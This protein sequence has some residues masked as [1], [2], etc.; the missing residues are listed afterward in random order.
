MNKNRISSTM[1]R[2]IRVVILL[3]MFFSNLDFASAETAIPQENNS[4]ARA[5]NNSSVEAETTPTPA[6][7]ENPTSI[8]TEAGALPEPARP[9][10]LLAAAIQAGDYPVQTASSLGVTLPDRFGP[11]RNDPAEGIPDHAYSPFDESKNSEHPCP[12]GGCD[13]VPGQVLVKFEPGL[14]MTALSVQGIIQ[15]E[16]VFP[17]ASAPE[18]GAQVISPD[19]SSIPMPDLTLWYRATFS[20]DLDVTSVVADLAGTPGIQQAAP[21][22]LRKPVGSF[23]EPG[24]PDAIPSAD[25]TTAQAAFSDPLYAQQWHLGAANVPQA[26]DY[27]ESQGLPPG[28]SRDIIVAVIDTGVDYTHPDLAANMWVN[29]AEFGG[30]PGV[31][32]DGN[33]FVDDIYGA[34]VVSNQHSGDPMDDHGHGTHV[35][36]II[37][38]QAGNGIGGV[39]V[40]YNVQIMAIK[41]AQYSGALSSSDIAEGVYYAVQKGADVINM[42]F[43]GYARSQVEE[44]ALAVAFGQAVLVAAAGNDGLVNLPCP[45]GRDMYPAAYNWVLGVMASKQASDIS[46]WQ[47]GFSNFDCV[48]HDTHEYELMAPGVDIWS[49]LPVNQYAAWDGTSMAAPIVSGIAALAR[50][51]WSDKDLYSSRFIMGQIAA[52]AAPVANAYAALTVAPQPELKYMEH[53]LFD[54]AA[55]ATGNDADGIVDAGETIDLAIVIRNHWGKADPVSVKLE[56]WAEGAFQADPYVTMITDTVDYGAIGSYNWDD[57]GLIYDSEGIITGVGNPF[58]FSVDPNTP[59]DHIIPFLLTMTTHNGLDP[60]DTTVY[61]FQSRFYL[62]VQRGRELPYIISENM[63]LTK[64]YY[65]LVS[66]Q[67]LIPAGVTLTI[68]EGTQIQFWTSDPEDPYHQNV[69]PYLQVE[70][71][72]I[73]QGLEYEPVEFFSGANYS[74]FAVQLSQVGNGHVE[75]HYT[76]VLNPLLGVTPSSGNAPLDLIDHVYFAQEGSNSFVL[77]RDDTGRLTAAV[78]TLRGYAI[79][80]SILDKMGGGDG[81]IEISS[82]RYR[83]YRVTSSL[84][85]STLFTLGDYYWGSPPIDIQDTV[86]LVN[87]RDS[88]ASNAYG[89]GY[90]CNSCDSSIGQT[91]NQVR[92]NA[93]LNRW[94]DPD[95]NHWMRITALSMAEFLGPV[96]RNW[97]FYIN[98][99]FWGTTSTTLIN[100]AI[101][102]FNDNFNLPHIE[103]Q[104]ILTT[105]PETAYPFVVDVILSTA[106]DPDAAVVSAEPVTFTVTFNRDMDTA[107]QPAVSFGPDVPLTD[108]TIHPID[109]GWQDPRTWTGTFNVNPMTGDGYQLIRVAG[110][111]AVDDPWLVTGDDAGRFRFE[112]ITSGTESMNLQATGGEGYVDLSWTQDDFEL[113]SGFNLYR[114]TSQAGAYSRINSSIIPPAERSYRDTSVTPGQPYYYKFTIVK[115]DMSE[116]DFSNLTQ[117]TPLDT[118]PP[119]LIHTAITSA[120]PGLPLTISAEATDNVAVTGLTLYYRH[121]GET[122][123]LTRAMLNTTGNSY[124]ATIEG[125]RLTSPGL[126]YYLEATDGISFTRN[127]RAENPNIVMVDDRPVVTIVTPN[128]GLAA[129]G[130]LVTISGSNFKAGATVKFGGSIASNVVVVSSNQITATTPAHYPAM[131]DVH[132]NNPDAQ[133]GVLLNGFT[134]ESPSALISLPETGGGTGNVLTVPINAANVHGMVA[135]SLTVSY[136]P[137]VIQ[138]LSASTG[139]LTAG[140]TLASNLATVG[141]VRLSLISPGGGVDGSGVLANI[142]FEVIGAPG[143]NSTLVIS[144]I[145]LNDGAIPVET[146]DGLFHVDDVYNVSGAVTFWN[147]GL[148]VPGTTL[149]LTGDRVYSGTSGTD[150]NYTIQGASMGDYI[151]AASKPD[152]DNGISAFDASLV[153][154]HDVGL[155]TLA[156]Y[157][158]IAGDVNNSG[159]ITS[160][161]AYY[162]LQKSVNLI[163]LPFPGSGKAWA[164][165]PSQ[166][167]I[168]GLNGNLT[169]QNFTAVLLGDV[170]GNWTDPGPLQGATV[171]PFPSAATAASVLTVGSDSV[172]PGQTVDI[173]INLM[174]TDADLYGA[175]L[176]L[177][178]DPTH[179]TVTHVGLGT[180]AGG[181]SLASNLTIPGVV[182]IAMAGAT[183]INTNGELIVL[184]VDAIGTPGSETALSLTTGALNEGAIPSTLN[185]GMVRIAIP[186]VAD[187]SATPLAGPAPLLV[188]FSNFSSGDW[189]TST[190]DFGDGNTSVS[191]NPSHQYSSAGSFTISLTVSGQG[192]SDTKTINS[193]IQVSTLSVSGNIQYWSGVKPIPGVQSTLAGINT[194]SDTTDP[195]GNYSI[196]DI[197]TGDYDL[198][199]SKSDNINGITAYDAAFVLQH[200]AELITMTGDQATAADVDQSGII[201]A[202]DASLILQK[203]VGLISGS[204]P[205][206]SNMWVFNPESRT[207]PNLGSDQSNQDFIGILLGDPTGNWIAEASFQKV[208]NKSASAILSIDATVPDTDGIV[209]ATISL[210]PNLMDVYGI[211]LVLSYDPTHVSVANIAP[212]NATHWLFAYNTDEPGIIRLGMANT[213][214]LGAS[215]QMAVIQF[216]LNDVNRMSIFEPVNGSINEGDVPIEMTGANLGVPFKIYLPLILR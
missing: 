181:W 22:Y 108:Y 198:S 190:W 69:N 50:T 160:M 48:P 38:A 178:Y 28:G 65:W 76:K 124:Y 87:Y 54:T 83:T 175:D 96:D 164:F 215:K 115:S 42:S 93:I 150:G 64:D 35:A 174:I 206:V 1:G 131:V 170:S 183:P 103:Y 185:A 166:R 146:T 4:P 147:A 18:M 62:I 162:I 99:N 127:G 27:L 10:D 135:G 26:W 173:P 43:G 213:Q 201:S 72:L 125:S 161:D 179:I 168:T 36:G 129:G 152:G 155:I 73:V 199:P 98:A 130:T 106:S 176:T 107:I 134:F 12:P 140:W 121:H 187:F 52:N 172:L 189:T 195:S 100:T 114:S 208:S 214:P 88:S 165:D 143:S 116:S 149:S 8:L 177:S 71:N 86:F 159:A 192:G 7:T 212:G 141:Q 90:L 77:F 46:G 204:F 30:T 110:A 112:V 33:G 16:P 111:V 74:G 123:Y 29:P 56:A 91:N 20:E 202:L 137:A 210:D 133:S 139:S 102:D 84:F 136:D 55:Q 24:N 188:N 2:L 82:D 211:D 89:V 97:T 163:S 85:D 200:A 118:I 80:Y 132:V 19:G 142:E 68:T 21:D 47:A 209:T 151:L 145:L 207:Y 57:N 191:P 70:G 128:R 120:D 15:L 41:A 6:P 40:A 182:K 148:A 61:T 157:A 49:T 101:H 39:G 63:I 171:E 14:Q 167:T 156:G 23:D 153:M 3:S 105:A 117:A 58:Q 9:G 67:T 193:Y 75:L 158:A 44:D 126:E 94:W 59:N 119:V 79:D 197:L 92:N 5:I 113:L 196:N 25:P 104:P 31:D 34:N 203:S 37:A 11:Q 180:L 144:N 60:L 216:Q 66:D 184:S 205:G 186:A 45:G 109:G 194:Y 17:N 13:F 138:A 122:T 53:W 81:L 51:R 95:I 78:N 32:D 169:G 154:Q